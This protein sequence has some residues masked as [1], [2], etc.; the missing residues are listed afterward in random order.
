MT[1]ENAFS[2]RRPLTIGLLALA[3]L[4]GGFGTWSVLANISGAVIVPGAIEVDQNR[5]VVQHPDG[6]VVAKINVKEGDPV[7]AGDIL[8]QLD[9]TLLRSRLNVIEGQYFEQT[10]RAARLAAERDNLETTTFPDELVSTA[11]SRPDLAE[12]IA[13]Q[14]RLFTSRRDTL[15]T[16]VG[17]LRKRMGQID[18]QIGGL[19]AQEDAL[20]QQLRLIREELTNQKALLNKGLTQ[21]SRVLALQREEASLSGQIGRLVASRA[22]AEGRV[23]EI[24]LQITQL[25]AQRREEAI[26]QLRDLETTRLD[27]AEQR[28]SLREQLS[29]L[30]IRAPVSGIVHGMNVF[31]ERSVLRPADPIMYLVPQD[32]PLLIAAQVDPIHVDQ[33]HVGQPVRLQFAAF[34]SRTTP[35]LNGTVVTLSPDAFQDDTTGLSYYRAEVH[36]DPGEADKLPN[37]ATLLP[38]MPVTG[39]IRT[40][41]RTPLAYLVEPFT[42]YFDK[43]FR[44]R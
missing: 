31:A 37:G 15:A 8:L 30:D 28:I 43:A 25:S 44:D 4:V 18:A 20:E 36:L 19:R 2:A 41:D 9:A 27:L 34:S 6:G 24:E 12:L 33:V 5:Q 16:Q 11:T 10:A 38:G 29:R 13:G 35:E 21:A 23:T 3:L 1:T 40:E 39:F 14:T 7:I 22:E 42:S 17:Q 26:S 32:R